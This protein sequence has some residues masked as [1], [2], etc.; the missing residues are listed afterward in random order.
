MQVQSLLLEAQHNNKWGSTQRN[1][2]LRWKQGRKTYPKRKG[3]G[4]PP[5]EEEHNKEAFKSFIYDSS[6]NLCLSSANYLASLSTPGLPQSPSQHAHTIVFQD[7]FQLRG[8]WNHIL[9]SH[10]MGQ[11]T[12][13][14]DPKEPFCTCEMSLLPQGQGIYDL[15]I[16]Q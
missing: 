3:I 2:F 13:L 8:P 16:L 5:R 10:I 12:I 14:F 1:G 4:V 15:L 9:T 6:S 7:G 11:Y